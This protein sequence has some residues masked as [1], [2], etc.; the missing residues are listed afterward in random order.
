MKI[1]NNIVSQILIFFFFDFIICHRL[2]MYIDI[3]VPNTNLQI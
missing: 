2:L 3:N 1:Y